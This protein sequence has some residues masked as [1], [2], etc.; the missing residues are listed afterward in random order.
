MGMSVFTF[1]LK[2]FQSFSL[3]L[4]LTMLVL[5]SSPTF[6]TFEEPSWATLSV[7]F[8]FMEVLPDLASRNLEICSALPKVLPFPT[9]PL[10]DL[11]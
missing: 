10:P 1:Q 5:L 9:V 11:H 7:N 6:K 4:S 2:T 3:S 8:L